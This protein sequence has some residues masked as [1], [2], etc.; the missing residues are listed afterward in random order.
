M[1]A[2]TCFNRAA[3]HERRQGP[4]P[5]AAPAG[6]D[7]RC[8]PMLSARVDHWLA[9]LSLRRGR[10]HAGEQPVP[11]F[12]DTAAGRLRVAD[13]GGPGPTVV[14]VPDGPNAVEHCAQVR[15]LLTRQGVRV[16]C[17]DMP[18]F[19]L[20]V[21][22]ACYTH[23]LDEGASLV[24]EVLDQLAIDSAVLAFSCANGFYALR[25]AQLA[26]ARVAGLLLSQTPSL[27]DMQHWALRVVPK[28]LHF[29]VIGQFLGW[30]FRERA[31]SRWYGL[32]LP[33]G[34][35]PAP[36]RE[37]A[38]QAFRCGACFSLAGV[39]QGLLRE[40]PQ[41]ALCPIDTPCTVVWGN[42][43]RSHRRTEPASLLRHV[44]HA[45]VIQFRDCGHFPDLEQA[46]RF[47]GVLMAALPAWASRRAA[48]EGVPA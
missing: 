42:G 44:P 7:A 4:A 19:G 1:W 37:T 40:D 13:T 46:Q 31:A 17:F 27:G 5:W 45:Q 10:R 39:V 35:D 2:G 34:T 41:T 38:R 12:L 30:C 16:V 25:A 9:S 32:A 24:L 22:K 28:V 47:V 11:R 21:P 36:M 26:P 33:K 6:G 23:S 14:L 48:S 8:E 20:S 18:G 15:G 29:P 3:G 43:D